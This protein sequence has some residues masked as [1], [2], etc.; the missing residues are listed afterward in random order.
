ML[1][2]LR[3]NDRP[4]HVVQNHDLSTLRF[5]CFRRDDEDATSNFRHFDFPRPLQAANVTLAQ[6]CVH[7]EQGHACEA[8]RQFGK[9]SILLVLGNGVGR[10]PR[11]LQRSD[12]R[13]QASEPWATYLITI[14]TCGTTE[15]GFH[16]FQAAV[17][18]RGTNTIS[19]AVGN[20]ALK[21]RVMNL[22]EVERADQSRYF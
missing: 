3:L 2:A 6:A 17:D 7:G 15:N 18:P 20:K 19:D 11:L 9:E 5:E 12:Q 14:N 16:D 21:C 8:W 22:V 1:T 10:P 13:R 4:G